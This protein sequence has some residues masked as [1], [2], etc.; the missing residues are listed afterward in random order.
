M[1]AD[2]NV[3]SRARFAAP[4]FDLQL[5][6][7]LHR[8]TLESEVGWQS[9]FNALGVEPLG[10]WFEDVTEGLDAAL[11]RILSWLDL[12]VAGRTALERL[13]HQPQATELNTEWEERYR[14]Q[15]PDA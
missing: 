1:N 9:F 2:M 11:T 3:R 7:G 14:A 13:R 10:S 5:L 15:R 4:A 8:L 12:P 6:D